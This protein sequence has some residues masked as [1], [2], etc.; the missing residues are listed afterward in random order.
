[1]KRSQ[2]NRAPV[3]GKLTMLQLAMLRLSQTDNIAVF[4]TDAAF[5]DASYINTPGHFFNRIYQWGLVGKITTGV[6]SVDYPDLWEMR[7][8]TKVGVH[9]VGDLIIMV[10]S[11]CFACGKPDASMCVTCKRVPVCDAVCQRALTEVTLL[12]CRKE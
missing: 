8:E 10:K 1:M 6:R 2:A 12:S 7:F 4:A 11:I 3:Q 5:T 9:S